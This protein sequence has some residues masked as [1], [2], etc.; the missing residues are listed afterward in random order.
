[1]PARIANEWGEA[2]GTWRAALI[3]LAVTLF[4]ITIIVNLSASAIVNR[5]IRRS[6]GAN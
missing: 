2:E 1:M 4:I 3:G 6:Q 5:S